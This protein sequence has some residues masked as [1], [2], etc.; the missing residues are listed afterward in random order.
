[1]RGLCGCVTVI[2]VGGR[3]PHRGS[4]GPHTRQAAAARVAGRCLP[5]W[6]SWTLLGG[7]NRRQRQRARHP[8]TWRPV[9][10]I[11]SI[12][13]WLTVLGQC[14]KS[15]AHHDAAAGA[16]ISERLERIT[17]RLWH[18]DAIEAQAR[19]ENLAEDF[20]CLELPAD[21]LKAF[22]RL[23]AAFATD[24]A[25]KIM[26]FPTMTSDGAM[27]SRS[28]SRRP[29]ALGGGTVRNDAGDCGLAPIFPTGRRERLRS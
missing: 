13:S 14:A 10:R 24:I 11:S 19:I 18:A 5:A 25:D 7:R 1:M 22:A 28:R 6:R 26:P 3:R 27:E 9:P 12:D 20:H 23:T 29:A 16:E 2:V 21:G 17:C 4:N 8:A 15:V